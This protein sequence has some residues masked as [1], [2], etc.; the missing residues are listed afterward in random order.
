MMGAERIYG[1]LDSHKHLIITI[2]CFIKKTRIKNKIPNNGNLL[3]KLT[4]S[5]YLTKTII[6]YPDGEKIQNVQLEK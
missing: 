2:S 5:Q 3:L 6:S 4:L 1:I